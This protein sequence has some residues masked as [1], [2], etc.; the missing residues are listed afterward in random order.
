[1]NQVG[2][3][4][5]TVTYL[6]KETTFVIT[7]IERTSSEV[8]PSTGFASELFISEYIE[9]SSS[10]KAI[11]IYNGTGQT[12]DLSRYS[13]ALYG[14]G[15]KTAGNT[16]DLTGSLEHNGTYVVYNSQANSQIKGKGN[17]V[18]TVTFFNG[19][20]ALELRK[21]DQPIDTMGKVGEDPGTAWTKG[22]KSMAEQTL[23]RKADIT[24]PT[25]DFNFDEWDNFPTDTVDDLGVHLMNAPETENPSE[26][27]PSEEVPS[28]EIPSSE[29]PPSSESE[30][31]SS[32]ETPISSETPSSSE[33]IPPSSEPATSENPENNGC[34]GSIIGTSVMLTIFVVF[35]IGF[36]LLRHKKTI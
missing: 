27:I 3:Q 14:N 17:S 28:E 5:L 24:G 25:N 2:E 1:M 23:V 8:P 34:G 35:G 21:D 36:N 33:V 10:N 22:S 20:D 32:S 30:L 13:L 9:G 29:E 19:N 26:E 12:I 7:I 4:T 31:P 11:E 18:S 16:L 15:S 6:G